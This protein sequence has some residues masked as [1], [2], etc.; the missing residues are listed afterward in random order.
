MTG[1]PSIRFKLTLIYG[2]LFVITGLLLLTITYGLVRRDLVQSL[3]QQRTDRALERSSGGPPGSTTVIGI[4]RAEQRLALRQ[5]WRQ[6]ILAMLVMMVVVLVLGWLIAGQVL[7]PIRRITDHARTAS[8]ANLS[9]RIALDGPDDELRE[10]ADTVDSMLD[11]IQSAFDAQRFFSA[12]A[13]HELRTPLSVIRAQAEL[14][15][16]DPRTNPEARE[17]ANAIL[18]AALRSDHLIDGLLALARSETSVVAAKPVDLAEIAG[19][20]A[21]EC[22][23]E[24]TKAGVRLDLQVETAQ[25]RGDRILLDQMLANLIQNAI[26]H[27]EPGG[28]VQITVRTAESDS[29]VEVR[30][31]GPVLSDAEMANLFQPFS[32]GSWARSE[33]SGFGLGLAIVQSVARTHGGRVEAVSGPAGGLSVTVHLPAA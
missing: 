22:V 2:G 30:N 24:A 17:S 27:N 14:T 3:N 7:K 8:A 5:L 15:S 19:D 26:R 16:A 12:Q 9:E 28:Y 4:R 13:S 29:I 11:R 33:R 25:V 21:G 18:T 10:L 6:S 1:R 31:S 32:R 20:M 23:A